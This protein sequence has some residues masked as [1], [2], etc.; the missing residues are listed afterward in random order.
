MHVQGYG[1]PMHPPVMQRP[2]QPQSGQAQQQMMQPYPV[3]MQPRPSA[4]GPSPASRRSGNFQRS[5]SLS[6]TCA[7]M[8]LLINISVLLS[9]DVNCNKLA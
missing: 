7:H 4:A 3:Q 9:K 6:Q 8:H 2:M 1:M 5:L